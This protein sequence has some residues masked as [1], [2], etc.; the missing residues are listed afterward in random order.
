MVLLLIDLSFR[1]SP[2]F[3][4]P[5]LDHDAFGKVIIKKDDPEDRHRMNVV[6]ELGIQLFEMIK[7]RTEGFT[8]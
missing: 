3:S 6:L 8:S 1:K 4:R 5:A 7:M 2:L